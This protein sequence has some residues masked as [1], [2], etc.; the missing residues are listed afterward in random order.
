M[1]FMNAASAGRLLAAFYKIPPTR[2]VV[3]HD[4]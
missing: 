2:I 4:T 3:V 1:S